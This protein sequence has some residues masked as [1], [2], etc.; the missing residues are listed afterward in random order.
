MT[1]IDQLPYYLVYL[2]ILKKFIMSRIS[3]LLISNHHFLNAQQQGFQKSLSC[4][5]ALFNLQETI[6]HNMEQGSNI[7]VSFLDC[8]KAFDTVWRQGLMFKL[9]NTCIGVAGKSWMLINNWHEN[10]ASSIVVNQIQSEWF[11][12]NQGVRQ[13]GV[14]SFFVSCIYR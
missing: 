7:Y 6:Y 13:G 1:V 11:P 14:F 5:T 10:T 3:E 12:V 8:S 4:R 2:K 9:Y